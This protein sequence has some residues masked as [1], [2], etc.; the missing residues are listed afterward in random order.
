MIRVC[1]AGHVT[2]YKRCTQCGATSEPTPGVR[3]TSLKLKPRQTLKHL[4][5]IGKV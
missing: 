4:R 2:G 3:A 1:H 5:S